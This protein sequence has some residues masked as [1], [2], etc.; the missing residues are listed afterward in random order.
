MKGPGRLVISCAIVV[1]GA[2]QAHAQLTIR[3]TPAPAITAVAE[4]WYQDGEPVLYADHFYYPAGAQ[5]HFNGNEMIWAGD[6]LGVPLYSKPTMEPFSVVYVPLTGGLMQPYE[7]RREGALAG[8]AGSTAPSFPVASS[9]EPGLGMPVAPAA[10]A[11]TGPDAGS[12]PTAPR[13]AAWWTGFPLDLAGRPLPTRRQAANGVYVVFDGDR[14]FSSGPAAYVDVTTLTRIG[15]LQG[16]PVYTAPG[17]ESTIFVAV[18][19]G[20]E[21]VAPYSKRAR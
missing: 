16:L 15:E 5:V 19:R 2:T 4:Q 6:Y 11:G 17:A 8:T 13:A 9:A 10:P 20:R 1:S 21:F 14:W 12:L 3:A 18:A 7:R